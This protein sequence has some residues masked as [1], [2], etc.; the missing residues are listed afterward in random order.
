MSKYAHTIE[1]ENEN[2]MIQISLRDISRMLRDKNMF[3][4]I[5]LGIGLLRSLTDPNCS[6]KVALTASAT[7]KQEIIERLRNTITSPKI[8]L[9]NKTQF[10]SIDIEEA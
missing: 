5:I 7:M 3:D 2:E 10:D 1:N 9:N 6:F 4:E 8:K